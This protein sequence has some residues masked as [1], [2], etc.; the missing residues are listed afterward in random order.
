MKKIYWRPRAVSRTALVLIAIIA[1]AGLLIV[2]QSKGPQERP[3]FLEK[4]TAADK[5]QEAMEVIK[6]ARVEIGPP[7]ED[8]YDPAESGII[9]LPMSPVTSVSGDIT[10]KQ[11]SANPNFAAVLVD[12]LKEAGVNE[13]DVVAVACSG[14]FPA[15][16]IATYAAIET[17]GLKPIVISSAAASQFGANVPDLLWIDM[18]RILRDQ[19]VFSIKSVAAS[20]G[21]YE[22]MG[23]GLTEEGLRMVHDSIQRNGIPRLDTLINEA[24]KEGTLIR[25]VDPLAPPAKG[26]APSFEDNINMRL[27][28]YEDEAEGRPIKAY[29]NIGGGTVSVGRSIGK[30]LFY[31]GLNL[32]PPGRIPQLDGVMPR[33]INEGVPIIHLVQV[34]QLAERYGLPIAP[35]T[36]PEPS[37][38]GVF[39]ADDY[40]RPLVVTVLVLIILTMYGFIRSDI[41]FRIL[42][43]PSGKKSGDGRPEPMV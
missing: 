34:A 41:G 29:I 12:M 26:D 2:E 31:P 15:L 18:E 38:G 9:G 16:N 42:R 5:A 11:T 4:V 22:D 28:L 1:L 23:V 39:T 7:I 25:T 6:E 32:R 14:S 37:V 13:G 30:K 43:V 21:G 8:A 40:N 24:L 20:I 36:A 17:L 33:L 10:A 27:K 19:G 3:Y 35:T